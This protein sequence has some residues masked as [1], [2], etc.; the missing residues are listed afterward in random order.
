MNQDLETGNPI[1]SQESAT[2]SLENQPPTSRESELETQQPPANPSVTANPANPSVPTQTPETKPEEAQGDPADVVKDILSQEERERKERLIQS[3]TAKE[4]NDQKSAH[5]RELKAKDDEISRL[6]NLVDKLT[7]NKDE[8]VSDDSDDDDLYVPSGP[9]HNPDGT[10]NED[11][12]PEWVLRNQ[13]IQGKE[14]KSTQESLKEIA[15]NLKTSR[16]NEIDRAKASK[17]K[18]KFGLSDESYAIYKSLLEKDEVEAADFLWLE[19][20]EAEGQKAAIELQQQQRGNA[21][22]I[23]TTDAPTQV[24]STDDGVEAYAQQLASMPFGTERTNAFYNVVKQVPDEQLAS[25]IIERARE[26]TEQS[27]RAA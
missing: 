22:T 21:P 20:K 24:T 27:F 9:F 23:L 7:D 2:P 11:T 16:Q 6:T 14:M 15:E 12:L 10:I 18:E 1:E 5:G 17:Y 8:S 4:I 26:I 19:R 13:Q 25:R 3:A